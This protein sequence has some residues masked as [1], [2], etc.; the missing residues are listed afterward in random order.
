MKALDR[1]VR[2][3]VFKEL[4][5]CLRETGYRQPEHVAL[6]V[7]AA[8]HLGSVRMNISD[9]AAKI[10]RDFGPPVISRRRRQVGQILIVHGLYF[11]R[12]ADRRLLKRQPA[13]VAR[14]TSRRL[15]GSG[16]AVMRTV[17]LP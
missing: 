9:C 12:A 17:M 11:R 8:H 1:R 10:K 4:S 16:T 14:L 13:N 7:F 15:A 3:Q 2:V 5:H 6:A